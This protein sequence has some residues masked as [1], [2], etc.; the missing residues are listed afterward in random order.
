MLLEYLVHEAVVRR[1]NQLKSLYVQA[2]DNQLCSSFSTWSISQGS[3]TS[4][5]AFLR[6]NLF[7]FHP[8]EE[9][10]ITFVPWASLHL[11]LILLWLMWTQGHLFLDQ[12]FNLYI[13]NWGKVKGVSQGQS[14]NNHKGHVSKTN[15]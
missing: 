1:K 13:F 2:K 12:F 7:Q 14:F 15:F 9:G 3:R 6:Y 11:V 10:L 5:S 8:K 4:K